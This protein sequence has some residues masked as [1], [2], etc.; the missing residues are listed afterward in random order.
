[1]NLG[2]LSP[3]AAVEAD[4]PTAN[5][6]SWQKLPRRS[7]RAESEVAFGFERGFRPDLLVRSQSF[8][9]RDTYIGP[10]DRRRLG[11]ILE[12]MTR[13]AIPCRQLR[14]ETSDREFEQLIA[15]GRAKVLDIS[16]RNGMIN[17]AEARRKGAD[18]VSI[19]D[20]VVLGAWRRELPE[21]RQILA[22]ENAMKLDIVA[23][24][25]LWF[26][27]MGALSEA[28]R[29]TLLSNAAAFFQP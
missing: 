22:I 9:P 6:V 11:I 18:M 10:E 26:K 5:D 1:M 12:T 29:S 3:S 17:F 20:G 28:E 2:A 14:N 13:L 25:S 24:I 8:N 27:A 21:T 7:K 15:D 19:R 16:A 4:D 23:G